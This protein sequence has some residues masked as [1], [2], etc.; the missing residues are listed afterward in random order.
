MRRLI[1]GAAAVLALAGAARAHTPDTSGCRIDIRPDAVSFAFTFD[2]A[3]LS[4][5]ARLDA[6]G[7][8]RISR[9]E[10]A[11]AVP[12]IERFLR[13]NVLI[14][15]NERDAEFGEMSPPQWS[16][17]AGDFVP[18]SDYQTRLAT[19]TFRNPVLHAPDAVTIT[20]D[21]FGA[22]GE[23]HTVLGSFVWQGRENEVIFTQF[24]PDYLFD[25]GYR[26]AALDQFLGFL[27]LGVEHIFRGYDHIAFLLALLYVRRFAS[28]LKIV[29]AFSI[30]HTLT[31]AISALGWVSLPSRLVDTAVAATIVY[32][33]AENLWRGAADGTHRWKIAF[34][35]G[36]I[37]GFSFATVLRAM[38]LPQDGLVLS[39][40]GFNLGVE[41]GQIAIAAIFWPVIY[42]LTAR[43][44]APNV[45]FAVSSAL[46]LFGLAWLSERA[47]AL[48][49]MPI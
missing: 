14:A 48:H 35:F 32:V 22:L 36:L 15:L 24:E 37:H 4:K 9:E 33:A 31:L 2:F 25:T 7:D 6:N 28:L 49:F 20:F 39:L 41:L 10:F 17:D 11:A 21:F 16:A 19:F 40:L 12:A 44:W 29:T 27:H 26:V 42:W 1:L 46:C 38:G 47:F 45:R 18:E 43:T 13:G 5:M 3:T 34:G 8:G 23:R 30:A